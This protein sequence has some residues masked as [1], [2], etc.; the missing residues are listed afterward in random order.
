MDPERKLDSGVVTRGRTLPG[1][2]WAPWA[3]EE[4]GPGLTAWTQPTAGA[5]L[6]KIPLMMMAVGLLDT[7]Q[8]RVRLVGKWR[9]SD[10]VDQK[11][12]NL[13]KKSSSESRLFS[14]CGLLCLIPCVRQLLFHTS[15]V[16]LSCLPPEVRRS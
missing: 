2:E 15:Q 11:L 3:K 6:V 4:K 9:I 14:P 12:A 13:L 16:D 1:Q 7:E 5:R 10:P 8:E